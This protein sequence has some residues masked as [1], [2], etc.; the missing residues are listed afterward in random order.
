ME[1]EPPDV[2]RGRSQSLGAIYS[3]SQILNILVPQTAQIP[4]VAGRP[5]F[6]VICTAA[7]MSR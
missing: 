2:A 6:N 7:S 4:S 1:M 5:F 3:L